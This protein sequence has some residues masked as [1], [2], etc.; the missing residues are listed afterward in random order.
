MLAELEEI[1]TKSKPGNEYKLDHEHI[2]KLA[3]LLRDRRQLQKVEEQFRILKSLTKEQ[4]P[5]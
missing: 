3:E 5:I 4:N 1:L 2:V